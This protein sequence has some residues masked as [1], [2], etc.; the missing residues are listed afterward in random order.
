MIENDKQLPVTLHP[1][2]HLVADGLF[3]S[4][5]LVNVVK[6][7]PD[8]NAPGWKSFSNSTERKLEGSH[9]RM[10]GVATVLLLR[11]MELQAQGLAKAFGT[12]PLTMETT[13]GGYHLIEPGGYLA[14]HADFSRSPATGRYRWLNML[15]YLNHDWQ[16]EGGQLQLWDDDGPAVTVAPEFNRTVVF[17]TSGSSWHGHPVPN[18]RPRRSIAAYFYADEPAPGYIGD[19]STRWHPKAGQPD[20]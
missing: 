10:W 13:G 17:R 18:V 12:P 19:H 20:A 3:R 15:V 2:P 4:E 8:R 9:P 5:Q 7:F 6:E 11:Q 16:E 1:F 14:M